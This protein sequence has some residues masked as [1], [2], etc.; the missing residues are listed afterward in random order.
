MYFHTDSERDILWL[1]AVLDRASREGRKVRLDTTGGNL[2][3]K[4]GEGTWSPPIKGTPDPYRDS[5]M[6]KPSPCGTC[7]ER[8]IPYNPDRHDSQNCWA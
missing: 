5:A 1:A 3:V 2:K 7:D 4:I 6:N 8:G